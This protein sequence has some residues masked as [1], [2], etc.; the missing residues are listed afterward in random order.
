MQSPQWCLGDG[1]KA[2]VRANARARA[3]TELRQAG[4]ENGQ[5]MASRGVRRRGRNDAVTHHE[6]S[7]GA[8]GRGERDVA[9]PGLAVSD[10]VGGAFPQHDDQDDVERRVRTGR[11]QNRPH[12]SLL[13]CEWHGVPVAPGHHTWRMLTSRTEPAGGPAIRVQGTPYRSR[14]RQVGACAPGIAGSWPLVRRV[15]AL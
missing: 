3:A 4:A 12:R 6:E 9:V 7:R 11:G 10:D 13:G 14:V 5:S 15:M 8:A 2:T 1:A